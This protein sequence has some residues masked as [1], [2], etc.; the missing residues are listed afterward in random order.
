MKHFLS[1]FYF[2]IS[3]AVII[4]SNDIKAQTAPITVYPTVPGINVNNLK[5]NAASFDQNGYLWVGT[6][7]YGCLIFNSISNAWINLNTSNGLPSDS[8]NCLYFDSVAHWIGT[9]AGA[10]RYQG[11]PGSGGQLLASYT[12]PQLPSNDVNDILVDSQFVWFGTSAGLARLEKSSGAWQYPNVPN[13]YITKITQDPNGNLWVGTRMGLYY[14]SNNGVSWVGYTASNTNGAI[15]D[16]IFDLDYDINGRLWISSLTSNSLFRPCRISYFLNGQVMGFNTQELNSECI[17]PG[18]IRNA[19]LNFAKS[20]DYGVSFYSPGVITYNDYLKTT[21]CDF[22]IIDGSDPTCSWPQV[23]GRLIEFKS[24]GDLVVLSRQRQC[25]FSF[26]TAPVTSSVREIVCSYSQLD[27]NNVKAG[28]L[29]GSDMHWNL[30]DPRYEVPKG[31]GLQTVFTSAHWIGGIDAG[32]QVRVA[33]QTYRQTGLDFWAGPID[34]VSVPIDSS[35]VL[36]NQL[37]KVSKWEVEYFK[38]AFQNGT[39]VNQPPC[40]SNVPHC[41][42]NWPAKGNG[43][44]TGDLAPFADVDGNGVYNPLTGGD[45]PLIYGDQTIFKVYNDSL[46]TH[47]ESGGLPLGFEFQTFAYAFLC[48]TAVSTN[49]VLNQTTFYKTRVINKSPRDYTQVYFGYWVDMDLGYYLDDYVGC[50]I[51]RNVGFAYNGDPDDETASGYGQNPPIMNVK[52][53][54]GPIAPIGDGI[55]NN[56]NGV[57]DEAGEY[58]GMNHFHYYNN[59]NTPS[60]NPSGFLDFYNYMKSVWRDGQ[61]VTYGGDGRTAGAPSANFMFPG[62]SDPVNFTTQGQWTEATA[63]II[64]SDRRFLMS[65]GPFSI[66]IGDTVEFDYAYV[67]SRDSLNGGPANFALNNANLDRVQNWFDNNSFP[68]CAV[69]SL[70]INIPSEFENDLVLSPN[71]TSDYFELY[72]NSIDLLG[73]E[74]QIY[75]SSGRMILASVYDGSAIEVSR[76]YSGVYFVKV[77]H[78]GGVGSLKLVI[79]N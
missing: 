14:S 61:H 11:L 36:F 73:A 27:V 10:I 24:N 8:V 16:T 70:G 30:S 9:K 22:E 69:Y 28:I 3:F 12:S 55:D 72:S 38:N 42:L 23:A 60:G 18:S 76:L 4:S 41:I 31:S 51:S 39:L 52:V 64:P 66:G 32:G 40:N 21:L 6:F 2:I 68:S 44:I 74:I 75:D 79:T 13:S 50:D 19:A 71:P 54:K 58:Y 35:A 49:K 45:Y 15:N 65:T 37:Y 33:A 62:S 29:T 25:F 46:D 77:F 5:N 63:G 34:G 56:N 67:F 78:K 1:N 47:T 26:P 7:P 20:N 53:L 59:D 17:S 57:I 48:D 43:V